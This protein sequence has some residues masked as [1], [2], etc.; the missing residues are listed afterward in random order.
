MDELVEKI[1]ALDKE[2]QNKISDLEKEK[3]ELSKYIKALRIKMSEEYAIK[4]KEQIA[5]VEQQIKSDYELRTKKITRDAKVK[6]KNIVS[7]YE[8]QNEL[9]IEQLVDFCLK[10]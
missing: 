7:Y 10:D 4:S 6:D 5:Q 3:Q 2:G 8:K 1:I 9:W